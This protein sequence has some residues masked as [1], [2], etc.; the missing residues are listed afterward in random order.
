M[1]KVVVDAYKLEEISSRMAKEFGTIPKGEEELHVFT[2][3]AMEGNLLKLHRQ[4][5]NRNGRHALEA[6]QIS[7]LTVDGYLRKIEYEYDRF[8]GAENQAFLHGLLMSFDPYTNQ[9]IEEIVV[10]SDPNFD[11]KEY[12]KLPVK[13]LLRIEKSVQLW[14]RE[15]GRN[16]Y[17]EF[18]EKQMGHTV[19]SDGKIYL[20]VPMKKV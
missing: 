3:H 15:W 12:F 5:P 4:D 20:S 7:L 6:I 2:L 9:E 18:F 10:E 14:T 19:E 8:A 13:C 17:F 11:T 16:G 1:K